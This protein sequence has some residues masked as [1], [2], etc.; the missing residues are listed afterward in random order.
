MRDYV[1]KGASGYV[2]K[3]IYKPNGMIVAVKVI[4]SRLN[5]FSQ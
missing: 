4:F 1:G 5:L 3:A 2:H